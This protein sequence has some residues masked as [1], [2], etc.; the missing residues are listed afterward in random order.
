[1]GALNEDASH[2]LLL[3][4]VCKVCTFIRLV[5]QVSVQANPG[6]LNTSTHSQ[7]DQ[8]LHTSSWGEKKKEGHSDG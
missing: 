6:S 2:L 8:S 4:F 3:L 5:S 7:G 1:M